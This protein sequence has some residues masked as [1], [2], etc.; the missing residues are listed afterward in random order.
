[1][2]KLLVL[3]ILALSLFGFNSSSF[4][5]DEGAKASD[6]GQTTAEEA[7]K[8]KKKGAEEEPECE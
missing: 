3:F 8:K 1:M 5:A 2:N 4:A 7:K 6:Q